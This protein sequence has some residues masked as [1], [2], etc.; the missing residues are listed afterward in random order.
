MI[1]LENNLAENHSPGDLAA[2]AGLSALRFK[3]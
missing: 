2:A 3:N 1:E